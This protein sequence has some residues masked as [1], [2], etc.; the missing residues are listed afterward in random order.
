[1]TMITFMMMMMNTTK[2][3]VVILGPTAS[4][5]TA[6][7]IE[8]AKKLKT[9]II[10]CD[11][12]Q[13]YKELKIGSAP[14]SKKELK[15]IKHHFIQNLSI[16]EDYNIG[17]FEND[18]INTITKLFKTFNTLI[19]VGGSGLYIDAVCNGIDLIPKTPKKIREKV[20]EYFDS[21]GLECLKEKIKEID[22]EFYEKADKNNPQRLKRCLEVY[23]ETGKKI[24]T[25]HK[26]EKKKRDFEI[27]K[28]GIKTERE[29]LYKKINNRVDEMINDG[30]IEEASTLF[31]HRGLNA[32]NTV[33]YK[34]IFNYLDKNNDVEDAI[35]EIKKNTRRFA[36]RQL[37]W[38]R[39]DSTIN[40]FLKSEKNKIIDFILK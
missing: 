2:K 20:N 35:E 38:F 24:S 5:K 18:A 13:F 26:K 7:S 32:L 3:L 25:F 12:R 11:S 21:K 36:K 23:L 34:E 37:T 9:E 40:W 15:L 4:G 6:L 16:N 39:K 8:I 14:P 33:G 29:N 19:L 27:I 28:I 1:M 30:L 10:S 31:K 17:Q 22:P